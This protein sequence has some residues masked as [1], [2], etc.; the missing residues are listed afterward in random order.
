MADPFESAWLKWG[1]A[2]VDADALAR[3]TRAMA[4][5]GNVQ[6]PIGLRSEYDAK[7][8]CIVVTVASFENP[9]PKH[10]GLLLGN[11]VHNFRSA[12]D[13][14]AWALYKRAKTPN[15]PAKREDFVYFPIADSTSRE[16]GTSTV[17]FFGW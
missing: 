8:R 11:T 3:E 6:V 4:S 13:H 16:R 10:W 12:L 17:T 2:V 5:K 7:C 1:W 14:V 9:F 15:L